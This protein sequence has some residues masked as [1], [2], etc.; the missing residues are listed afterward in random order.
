MH[1]DTQRCSV[2][3]KIANFT[4]WLFLYPFCI[5]LS[6]EL[7]LLHKPIGSRKQLFVY[8]Q[9]HLTLLNFGQNLLITSLS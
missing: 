8:V 9:I 2:A 3:Q 1:I 6:R 5:I 7:S 4:R